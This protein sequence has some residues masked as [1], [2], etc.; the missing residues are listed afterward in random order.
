MAHAVASEAIAGLIAFLVGDA[1]AQVSG[2]I[3]PAYGG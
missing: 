2:A 3:A 1:A